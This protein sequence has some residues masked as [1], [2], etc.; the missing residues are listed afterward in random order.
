[1]EDAIN[2]LPKNLVATVAGAMSNIL[3]VATNTTKFVTGNT[4]E[5]VIKEWKNDRTSNVKM[6]NNYMI[7][8]D[9]RQEKT[10]EGYDKIRN[11]ATIDDIEA[12]KFYN[13]DEEKS[14]YHTYELDKNDNPVNIIS[15]AQQGYQK[16]VHDDGYEIVIEVDKNRNILSLVEDPVNTGTYNHSKPEGLTGNWNH[17][18]LD[19]VPY[20]F[21]GNDEKILK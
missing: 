21:H 18:L 13:L 16:Y 17:I 8:Y 12:Q 10:K 4:N 1:M 15:G 7:N 11:V 20:F 2:N 6:L 9:R 5:G 14:I 3:D 19:V